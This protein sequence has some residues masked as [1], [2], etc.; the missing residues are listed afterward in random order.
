MLN[1]KILRK[2]LIENARH[3]VKIYARVSIVNNAN[4][5]KETIFVVCKNTKNML[6][7]IV[8]ITIKV[9]IRQSYEEDT[10]FMQRKNKRNNKKIFF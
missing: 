3:H 5:S 2:T 8:D 9:M 6:L 1:Q 10:S 4:H 7:S